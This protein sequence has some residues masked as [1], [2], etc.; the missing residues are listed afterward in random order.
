MPRS[1][2]AGPLREVERSRHAVRALPAQVVERPG[3]RPVAVE[4]P[5]AG[6]V[7]PRLAV[8]PGV[9]PQDPLEAFDRPLRLAQVQR[10]DPELGERRDVRG[11]H[12]QRTLERRARVEVAPQVAVDLPQSRPQL[13]RRRD[14]DRALERR[15]GLL[16]PIQRLQRARAPGQRLRM[17][18]RALQRSRRTRARPRST[19]G[20]PGARA[21]GSPARP[22]APA[23]GGSPAA[24]SR[25]PPRR[26]RRASTPA[27]GCSAARRSRARDRPRARARRARRPARRAPARAPPRAPARARARDGPRGRAPA[28]RA[29]P[30]L[31]PA[32]GARAQVRA[33]A[34]DR[35]ARARHARSNTPRAAPS[36]PV[37]RCANPSSGARRRA[38]A[39][40]RAR[41]RPAR[42]PRAPARSR[43]GPRASSSASA[44]SCGSSACARSRNGTASVTSPAPAS[45]RPQRATSA[46]SSGDACDGALEMRARARQVARLQRRLRLL[47]GALP[48]RPGRPASHPVAQSREHQPN[49]AAA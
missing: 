36:A 1:V 8:E 15:F 19:P 37:A 47:H 16:E 11:V 20:P 41:P 17:I 49:R 23:G 9:A 29:P 35:T 7:P 43:A 46:A 38:P 18:G 40:A 24:A 13:G 34:P 33:P 6:D 27:R 21:P 25:S 48:R 45:S 10:H 26:D 22:P 14:R 3:V 2:L 5:R 32:R 30:P 44:A 42:A 28:P 4:E 31:V 39:R 12:R